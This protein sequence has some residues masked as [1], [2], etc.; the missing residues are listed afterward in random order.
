MATHLIHRQVLDL[1]YTD[2]RKAK[3]AMNQ[4]TDRF[5]T[6]WQPIIAEVLDEL[7]SEG[8]WIRLERVEVDLGKIRENLSPELFR[9]KLKEALKTQLLKQ[10]PEKSFSEFS[11]K[12]PGLAF[13]QDER[14]PL[15]L[16]IYLLQTGRKPWW[17]SHSKKENIR[18][19]IRKLTQE[20]P[21]EFS[22]WLQTASFTPTMLLRLENHLPPKEI[23][24][25]LSIGFSE[26]QKQGMILIESLATAFSPEIHSQT[27]LDKKWEKSMLQAFF[28]PENQFQDQISSWIKTNL[29][30][31][32]SP[33]SS[34]PPSLEALTELF[35]LLIPKGYTQPSKLPILEKAWTKWIQTP[36]YKK[37]RPSKSSLAPTQSTEILKFRE[38]V[39]TGFVAKEKT[40]SF[41]SEQLAQDKLGRKSPVVSTSE[42]LVLDETIP[43]SNA[44]LVLLAPFLPYFFRGLGLVESKQFVSPE[45]QNRGAL[46]LQA[47]L[48]D[49][50]SY[51]E[52][53]LILN[54]I[55]CGID[56]SEPIEVSFSPSESEKEEIKNL[57]DAMVSQWS[58]LKSTSGKSMAMGF[59]PREGSLKRTGRGYQLTVPRISI[60]ILLNRLPWAIS[61]IKLPWMNETLFTEW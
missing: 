51:N 54:K 2:Q 33:A 31:S 55:I 7:D 15:A 13:P 24:E 50:F 12:N 49:S 46:L 17:A 56:P 30:L 6:D 57:L 25:I 8:N 61:I 21:R 3:A 60:D 36:V 38:L 19:L 47:L 1:R 41:T 34:F 43:V 58:A 52:S 10:I 37:A 35:A 27:E 44:G 29:G 5:Q 28:L 53:D 14:K 48:D 59:F 40:L 9:Q 20:N 18:S 42:K 39:K 22:A 32:S 16:L 26:K 23:R 45:A 4:W 11:G